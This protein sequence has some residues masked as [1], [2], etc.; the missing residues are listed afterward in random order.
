M[1]YCS[2][3]W[4]SSMM[5]AAKPCFNY[6]KPDINRIK[7]EFLNSTISIGSRYFS[8]TMDQSLLA[9]KSQLTRLEQRFVPVSNVCRRKKEPW[10]IHKTLKLIQGKHRVY[11][12]YKDN[13]HPAYVKANK[14][15]TRELKIW[16]RLANVCA[17]HKKGNGSKLENYRPISLD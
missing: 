10:L 7:S 4:G 13:T 8:G 5:I 3:Y 2:I 14:K 17:I 1:L 15:A 9:F 11:N 6:A 12:R 16:R